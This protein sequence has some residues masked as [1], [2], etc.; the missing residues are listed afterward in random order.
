MQTGTAS[1]RGLGVMP[2][3]H[4][5]QKKRRDNEPK[6]HHEQFRAVVGRQ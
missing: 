2:R 5:G 3:E 6:F 4:G 1:A